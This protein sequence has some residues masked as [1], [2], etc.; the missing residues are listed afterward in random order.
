MS[1]TV[2]PISEVPVMFILSVEVSTVYYGYN[3]VIS[4]FFRD[5]NIIL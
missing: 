1:N 2:Y 4:F 5:V 3:T